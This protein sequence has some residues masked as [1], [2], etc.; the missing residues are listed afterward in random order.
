MN[1]FRLAKSDKGTSSD[2]AH[3]LKPSQF[4]G[5]FSGCT[6]VQMA[7]KEISHLM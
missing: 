6:R 2:V 7:Q 1:P 5:T 3:P 4:P